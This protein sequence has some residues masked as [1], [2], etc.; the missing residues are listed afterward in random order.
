MALNVT[1]GDS[2][3][4]VEESK[5]T[6]RLGYIRQS[7]QAVYAKS[8]LCTVFHDIYRNLYRGRR[9]CQQPHFYEGLESWAHKDQQ[10][11]TQI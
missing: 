10:R 3:H 6:I 7:T 1:D 5:S 11:R 2:K 9:Q 4:M 8:F